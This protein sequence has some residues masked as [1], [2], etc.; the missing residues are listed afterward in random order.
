MNKNENQASDLLVDN[1]SQPCFKLTLD[2]RPWYRAYIVSTSG[3]ITTI[4]WFLKNK[5]PYKRDD[6]EKKLHYC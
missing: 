2:S 5:L 4:S 6:N 3:F 1:C